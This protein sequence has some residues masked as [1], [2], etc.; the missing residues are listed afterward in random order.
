MTEP[1]RCPFE[2]MFFSV[3]LFLRERK[4]ERERERQSSSE[5]SELWQSSEREGNT[6]SEAAPGSELSVQS[7][8]WGLN[9]RTVR[10]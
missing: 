2:K 10:S 3:F 9:S 5:G 7:P 1:P 6:E 4:R 8:T